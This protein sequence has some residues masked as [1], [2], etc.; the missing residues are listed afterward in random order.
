MIKT[1]LELLYTELLYTE[2]YSPPFYF[3]SR[4]SRIIVRRI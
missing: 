1:P 4:F 3:R 2:K